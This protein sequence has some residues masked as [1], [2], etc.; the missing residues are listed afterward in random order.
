[1][2]VCGQ[3]GREL[4]IGDWPMCDSPGG[5]GSTRPEWAQR[6]DPIVVHRSA[7][8]QYRFPGSVGA[9]VPVGFEKVELRTRGEVERVLKAADARDNARAEI[10]LH[11]EHEN[12]EAGRRER[13]GEL[14]REMPHRS[15]LFAD[16][17]RA[18][19]ARQDAKPRRRAEGRTYVEALEFDSSNREAWRD[20]R[21]DWRGRRA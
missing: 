11:R 15:P 3:C 14:L 17:V 19:I 10:D 12:F 6:F 13:R 16:M 8:G 2:T 18:A 20:A 4:Q 7:D 5:H 21:T 1:M 9:P